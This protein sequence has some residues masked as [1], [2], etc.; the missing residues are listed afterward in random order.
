M[1]KVQFH[2][3]D[4]FFFHYFKGLKDFSFLHTM[5]KNIKIFFYNIYEI[6]EHIKS[7]YEFYFHFY[8]FQQSWKQ[9]IMS[10]CLSVYPPVSINILCFFRNLWMLLFLIIAQSRVQ[11]KFAARLVYLY[12]QSKVFHLI[13][14]NRKN[15]VKWMLKILHSFKH[16]YFDMQCK[17]K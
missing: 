16:N 4:Y 13:M 17:E 9:L 3:H 14:A 1:K 6:N 5:N 2:T 15:R 11:I 12:R 10:I 7:K 8:I